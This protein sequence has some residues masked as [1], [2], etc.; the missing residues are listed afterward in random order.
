M[1]KTQ[2]PVLCMINL[3]LQ[4]ENF[5]KAYNKKQSSSATELSNTEFFIL[6]EIHRFDGSIDNEILLKATYFTKQMLSKYVNQL[7]E[8]KMV[9]T[10]F[11]ENNLKKKVI[12]L[13][14]DGNVAVAGIME[15]IIRY[16]KEICSGLTSDEYTRLT[17]YCRKFFE[18]VRVY[19]KKLD[20]PLGEWPPIVHYVLKSYRAVRNYIKKNNPDLKLDFY[21]LLM[22]YVISVEKKVNFK[23]LEKF[24]FTGQTNVV[25]VAKKLENSGYITTAFNEDDK[26][27]KNAFVTEKGQF[28]SD[29]YTKRAEENENVMLDGITP[30]QR[31][32]FIKLLNII[33]ENSERYYPAFLKA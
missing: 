24:L 13:T 20:I 17:N 11:K 29:A 7:V 6:L 10:S 5:T 8:K 19:K 3:G 31:K 14:E 26:R 2:L 22:L 28:I 30:I 32:E 1:K 18:N 33:C 23:E 9:F 25:R 15:E 27:V 21:E 16:D 12:N 4:I